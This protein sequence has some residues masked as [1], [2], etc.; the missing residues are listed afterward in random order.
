MQIVQSDIGIRLC[1]EVDK[2]VGPGMQHGYRADVPPGTCVS[3][4]ICVV[5]SNYEAARQGDSLRLPPG[6]HYL[7]DA[8]AQ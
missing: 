3:D 2:A 6:S 8:Q 1:V 4:R 7:M 5:S